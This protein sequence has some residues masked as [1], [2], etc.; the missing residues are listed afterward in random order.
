MALYVA[1]STT[2]ASSD[3]SV[4]HGSASAQ[5]LS[6]K[7]VT[8]RLT[9]TPSGVYAQSRKMEK[10]TCM[11]IHA[12]KPYSAVLE[13]APCDA[14]TSFIVMAPV[15]RREALRGPQAGRFALSTP[16]RMAE[17]A[18]ARKAQELISKADKKLAS[19]FASLSGSKY[20]DAEELYSKAANQ[21]KVAKQCEHLRA[22]TH[23][24]EARAL[25]AATALGSV[26]HRGRGGRG[27]R[28]VGPVPSQDDLAIRCRQVVRGC[29]AVLQE[30]Q[31]RACAPP[32]VPALSAHR[33]RPLM[34]VLDL[35]AP[36]SLAHRSCVV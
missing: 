2:A 21:L 34:R 24:L 31:P 17:E 15:Q 6:G 12:T 9:R 3:T 29:S 8:P 18:A 28:E 10:D 23:H 25:T 30:N 11:A 1:Y 19:W 14:A 4:Q 22:C 13:R 5:C 32:P 20:E 36:W 33:R 16:P 35:F 7:Y 27:L 26:L